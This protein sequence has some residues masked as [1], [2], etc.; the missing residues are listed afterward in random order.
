M[1]YGRIFMTTATDKEIKALEGDFA[2]LRSD[3]T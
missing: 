3:M 2:T 1:K